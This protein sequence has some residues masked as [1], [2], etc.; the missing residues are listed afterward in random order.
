MLLGALRV[1][2]GQIVNVQGALAKVPEGDGVIGTAEAKLDWRAGNNPVFDTSGTASLVVKQGRFISLALV[3][4]GYA[5]S[6]D[7]VITKKTFE[8]LRERIVLDC[9]WRWEVFGQHEFDQF[10]RLTVR[11]LAGTGP[12]LAIVQSDPFGLL[13]G[14]TY[15]FDYEQLDTR[16]GTIDAGKRSIQH[17]AS[18]YLTGSEKFSETLSLVET[19]YA[20]PELADLRALRILGELTLIN[21]LTPR[22]ALTNGFTI[23]YDARPPDGVGRTDSELKVGALVTF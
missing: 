2:H 14:L 12:A 7:L 9:R 13:A 23:A 18:L 3:R 19:V 1:A 6:R 21:K 8:H 10:R 4:G 17:R 16:A 22:I 5:E 15:M 20:Q 11:A